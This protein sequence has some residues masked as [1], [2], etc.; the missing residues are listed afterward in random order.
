MNGLAIANQ[1]IDY[2]IGDQPYT[3]EIG[4]WNQPTKISAEKR[5]DSKECLQQVRQ[6]PEREVEVQ[7]DD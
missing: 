2:E 6:N 1:Q 5:V 7:K 4:E 3:D